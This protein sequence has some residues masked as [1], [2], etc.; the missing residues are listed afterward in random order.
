[1]VDVESPETPLTISNHEEIARLGLDRGH[2]EHACQSIFRG[3]T[4]TQYRTRLM[5]AG[6]AQSPSLGLTRSEIARYSLSRA[7]LGAMN[8]E[9]G[10][11]PG[12]EGEIDAELAK[13]FRTTRN[14]PH[15]VHVPADIFMA[16]RADTV[17]SAAGGGYLVET[18]NLV[19][20]VGTALARSIAGLLPLTILEG[21]IG[22]VNVPTLKSA[23]T[24]GE[25]PSET[26]QAAESDQTFGQVALSP[27][28]EGAFTQVSGLFLKQTSA[29]AQAWLARQITSAFAA[30]L[31]Y[32]MLRGTG[33]GG[34]PTSVINGATGSADGASIELADVLTL[35][36]QLGNRLDGG[37]AYLAD[38][39]TAALLAARQKGS[40]TSSYLWEGGIFNGVMAGCPAY[41]TQNMP[42]S[43]LIFAAWQHVVLASWGSLVIETDPYTGFKAGLVGLRILHDFDVALLDQEAMSVA[44]SVT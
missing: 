33:T 23:G 31:E 30:R 9:Y 43:T 39:A 1:M 41:S 2:A 27:K 6:A 3:E 34:Q 28:T 10:T 36:T 37:G 22:N 26:S 7:L 32:L 13:R 17:A 21:L 18:T 19:G 20:F 5:L 42:A 44:P 40:G 24:Q 11:I 16:E 15:R 35:Q 14:Q 12:F 29:S 4:I 38:Q 8:V 25:L